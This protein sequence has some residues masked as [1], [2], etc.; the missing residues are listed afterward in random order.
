MNIIQ[1]IV[2]SY[3]FFGLEFKFDNVAFS[4]GGFSVYWYGIIIA[5][6][7]LLAL[8][9]GYKNA[10]RYNI[11]KDRMIDVVIVGLIGAIVCARLYYLI[12]DGISLSEYPTFKE[13]LNYICG[14]H[15]GGI[16]I[17]G[18][19]IGAFCF[20]G[21]TAKLRKVNMLD[22]FDLAATGF[23]IGQAVGRWGNFVNQEVYGKPTGSDWFGIGG[24]A[25]GEALVHPLFLYESVWCACCFLML[26]HIS[27]RRVFKGQI[28]LGYI[29][30]YT[31]GR[32]WLESMRNKSFILM[33]GAVSE[34]QLVCVAA[35]IGALIAYVILYR[36]NRYSV[37]ESDYQSVFGEI[38]DDEEQLAAAYELIG[39]NDDSTDSEIESAYNAVC[40]KYRAML[41]EQ[42]ELANAE[43]ATDFGEAPEIDADGMVEIDEQE[44][45]ARISAKLNELERAY[46]YICGYRLLAQNE[47]EGFY[48][49]NDSEDIINEDN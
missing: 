28:F 16:G 25:I 22:M 11:D 44:L 35:F 20:G 23:L 39:C 1:G 19:V 37:K 3:N 21:I 49:E 24:S 34:A 29:V 18:A 31:F 45:A 4:V 46:K 43:Q 30:L 2:R 41:P 26:H 8:L 47:R 13:K 15:N 40:D 17:F 12:G 9:Y 27:K 38:C 33:L 48:E 5:A 10:D 42:A 32:Y 6:G 14:I 7:F 36:R